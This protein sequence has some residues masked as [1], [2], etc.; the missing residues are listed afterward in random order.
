MSAGL[1]SILRVGRAP[2]HTSAFTINFCRTD[3]SCAAGV[4]EASL[5]FTENPSA[6]PNDYVLDLIIAGNGSPPRPG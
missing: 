1:L 2:A 6:D 5:T 4:T 3:G